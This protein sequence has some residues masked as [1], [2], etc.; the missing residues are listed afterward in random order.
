MKLKLGV[1]LVGLIGLL[2]ISEVCDA[3]CGGGAGRM[4][5]FR[6]RRSGG[7]AMQSYSYSMQSCGQSMQSQSFQMGNT[8]MTV[9]CSG[10]TCSVR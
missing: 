6:G 9:R 4:G 2:A 8:R 3:G 7:M 10:G 5:F 1:L